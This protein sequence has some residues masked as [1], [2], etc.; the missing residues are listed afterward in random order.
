[1]DMPYLS[2]VTFQFSQEGNTDGSTGLP[3]TDGC[4]ELIV[5]MQSAPGSLMDSPGY[6]VLR[7]RTGWSIN[8]P[9]DLTLVLKYVTNLFKQNEQTKK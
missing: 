4:E 2:L 6:L 7:T 8:E 3:E 5:E 9:E 1:M